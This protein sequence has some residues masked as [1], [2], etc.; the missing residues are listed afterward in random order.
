MQSEPLHYRKHIQ[1]F[2]DRIS[3]IIRIIL[4]QK[5]TEIFPSN[6]FLNY[7]IPD[8]SISRHDCNHGIIR[9]F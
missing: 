1:Y 9:R 8:K 7:H 5:M 6:S 2:K 3:Y 4:T